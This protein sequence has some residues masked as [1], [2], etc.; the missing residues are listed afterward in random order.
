MEGGDFW[1]SSYLFQLKSCIL[2]L[3]R[4]NIIS[5]T[6]LFSGK[7]SNQPIGLFW[8]VVRDLVEA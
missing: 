6:F 1:Y 4:F 2:T 8:S 7:K 3:N 5:V